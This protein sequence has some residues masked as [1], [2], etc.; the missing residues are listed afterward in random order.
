[1]HGL[2]SGIP[3][4]CGGDVCSC[5]GKYNIKVPQFF[6]SF[7]HAS[8]EGLDVGDVSLNGYRA[9]TQHHSL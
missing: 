4:L 9:V 2:A 8:F 6:S 3:L 1:M 5:I 7:R